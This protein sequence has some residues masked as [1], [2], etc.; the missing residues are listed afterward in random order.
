M[1]ILLLKFPFMYSYSHATLKIMQTE[2]VLV[3]TESAGIG[4][5]GVTY[6]V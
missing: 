2:A 1:Q 3:L 6:K 4:L 5:F